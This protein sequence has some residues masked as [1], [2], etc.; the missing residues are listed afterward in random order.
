MDR[1]LIQAVLSF[2]E[3]K[4]ENEKLELRPLIPAF[5][6]L[7]YMRRS[8]VE[9]HEFAKLQG[10]EGGYNAF[11]KWLR[12]NVDFE[13]ECAKYT[14]EFKAIVTGSRPVPKPDSGA[15]NEGSNKVLSGTDSC[16]PQKSEVPGASSTGSN[17]EKPGVS[18]PSSATENQ[19]SPRDILKKWQSPSYEDQLAEL[20]IKGKHDDQTRT[21]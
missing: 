17:K 14:D 2:C 18:E 20:G 4:Q 10:Y 16:S 3:G 11:A 8:I 19:P 9:I 1:N 12:R 13:A 7:H 5:A 21:R 15:T 6:L